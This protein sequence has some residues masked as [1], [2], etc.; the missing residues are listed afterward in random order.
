V[1]FATV[2]CLS[3]ILLQTD[4]CQQQEQKASIPPPDKPPAVQRFVPVPPPQAGMMG[5]P[6]TGFFALDTQMG[7]LCLTTG[8]YIPEK[9][10][11]L[12]T[13]DEDLRAN[14]TLK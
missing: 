14:P 10:E 11:R 2:L 5:V 1:K 12:P 9:Y 4:G 13:C 7:Q 6:W 8:I 3:T